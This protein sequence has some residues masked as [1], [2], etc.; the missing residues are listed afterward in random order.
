[1]ARPEYVHD[2]LE[3]GED[4][5]TIGHYD[6]LVLRPAYQPIYEPSENNTFSLYGL[7]GLI[8]PFDG[9]KAISPEELFAGIKDED[10]LF[11]E[12]MC[13][14]LHIRNYKLVGM[15]DKTLFLNV[16]VSCYPSVDV[17]EREL[18]FTFSQLARHGL[19]RHRLVFE[20]LETEVLELRVLKRICE[21]F[22]GNRFRFALDDFGARHSNL[23]RFLQTHPDIVKFDRKI[24]D[25]FTDDQNTHTLLHNLIKAFHSHGSHV[26][27]EGLETAEEVRL[28]D[29][30]DVGMFQGFA[31]AR[32]RTF[33]FDFDETVNIDAR[34]DTRALDAKAATTG[35]KLA[36]SRP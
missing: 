4:G 7:E 9:K 32:P 16:D 11:I 2:A 10:R 20:I 15:E 6:G 34:D 25:G 14:A 1:M 31:L 19:D 35:L 30:M 24:F 21:L 22:R 29:S 36:S 12:C 26:L 13:M 5:T 17:L 18:Y 23:E 3:V 28:A 33:P 8:R 27:M